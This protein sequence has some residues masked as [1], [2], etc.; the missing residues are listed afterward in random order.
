MPVWHSHW[1]NWGDEYPTCFQ[2]SMFE[3]AQ[4][5]WEIFQTVGVP[6][7]QRIKYKVCNFLWQ[8]LIL[9]KRSNSNGIASERQLRQVPKANWVMQRKCT[10]NLMLMSAGR[11]CWDDRRRISSLTCCAVAV[12]GHA[13]SAA[14]RAQLMSFP[15]SPHRTGLLWW[16][17]EE[18]ICRYWQLAHLACTTL[19]I[20]A[21]SDVTFYCSQR[22]WKCLT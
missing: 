7:C 3:M 6:P 14:H 19:P 20:A 8:S 21:E 9:I 18:I 2:K 15:A 4:I 16:S 10:G 12:P 17:V 1:G 11:H 13:V 5:R 22:Q